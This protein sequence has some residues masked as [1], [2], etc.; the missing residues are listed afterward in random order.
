VKEEVLSA[1]RTEHLRDSLQNGVCGIGRCRG[2]LEGLE[3][4]A[5]QDQDVGERASGVDRDDAGDL[6]LRRF[7]H[8]F[9]RPRPGAPL[10]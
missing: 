7:T 4:P 10:T 5:V 1:R 2:H 6:A 8:K 3:T 9:F